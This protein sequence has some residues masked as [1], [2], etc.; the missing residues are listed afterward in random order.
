MV[1][2]GTGRVWMLSFQVVD[3]GWVGGCGGE[4]RVDGS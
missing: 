1:S 2:G 3:G 4:K